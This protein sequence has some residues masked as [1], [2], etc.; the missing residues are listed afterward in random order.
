MSR[1]GRGQFAAVLA[2]IFAAGAAVA[3]LCMAEM[4]QAAELALRLSET[5]TAKYEHRAELYREDVEQWRSAYD[6]LAARSAAQ[7]AELEQLRAERFE[8]VAARREAERAVPE[9][10]AEAEREPEWTGS[11]AVHVYH[12]CPC[13]KCTGHRPGSA[14]Y[15]VTR[16]GTE[17]TEG[18]TVAVDPDVIPL[19]SEVLLNGRVY[20][21]EDTGVH[22]YA[23]DVY[24][25]EHER[26]VELGTYLTE[27]RWRAP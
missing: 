27:V 26:A 15:R 7:E 20:I 18:R 24:V 9:L 8:A 21:A 5:R 4:L 22:G 6:A 14:L 2:L 17:A 1:A 25:T 10:A 23:V 11:A 19:G 13:E 12:Y 3:V 16:T